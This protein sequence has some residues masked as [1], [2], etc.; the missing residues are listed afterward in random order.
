MLINTFELNDQ[1]FYHLP[2]LSVALHSFNNLSLFVNT[3]KH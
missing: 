1:M 3:N 2:Y